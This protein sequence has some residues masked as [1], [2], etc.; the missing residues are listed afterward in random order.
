M[1][2]GGAATSNRCRTLYFNDCVRRHR[3]HRLVMAQRAEEEAVAV[4]VIP[5]AVPAIPITAPVPAAVEDK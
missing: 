3:Q 1:H 5:A 4:V 2:L